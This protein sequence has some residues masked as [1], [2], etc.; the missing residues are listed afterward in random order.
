MQTEQTSVSIPHDASVALKT[1]K[2][3][4]QRHFLAVFFLAFMWGALGVDRMYLGKWGTGIIK[5][6][7][8]G[9]LGIWVVVDLILIMGGWMR[10]RYG[11]RMLQFE[12]Y[13]SFVY[14][15]V[16]VFAVIVGVIVL[17]NG[18]LL[19][20]ALTQLVTGMQ[21]GTLNIPWLEG[22]TQ[23]VPLPEGINDL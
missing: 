16:L 2:I 18:L 14:K 22:L 9:G 3:P 5:L 4:A 8:A 20:A 7:T 17:I 13:K 15:M 10:D 12:E 23:A 19:I 11:R 6:V 21:D 1:K